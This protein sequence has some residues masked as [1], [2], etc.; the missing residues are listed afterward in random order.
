ML[1]TKASVLL[2]ALGTMLGLAAGS[3]VYS[4]TR[5]EEHFSRASATTPAP[6]PPP[7]PTLRRLHCSPP[8]TQSDSGPALDVQTGV[9]GTLVAV[10]FFV[11]RFRLTYPYGHTR[12]R[13]LL[14]Y[15]MDSTTPVYITIG[16][17]HEDSL[18]ESL[19]EV[20]L[21]FDGLRPGPHKIRYALVSDYSSSIA[22]GSRCFLVHRR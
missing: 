7:P 9:N 19:Y 12:G 17:P 22:F 8:S 20:S 6:L 14:Y 16:T 15:Q 4:T 18:R 13:G 1:M 21:F 10:T 11:Y 2:V 5:I 3:S